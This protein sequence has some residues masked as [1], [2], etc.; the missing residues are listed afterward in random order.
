LK[1]RLFAFLFVSITLIVIFAFTLSYYVVKSESELLID[2]QIE[3]LS[4]SLISSNLTLQKLNQFEVTDNQ[5]SEIL[6]ED[7]INHVI[8]IFD[9]DQA[10]LY[11]NFTAQY[12]DVEFQNKLGWSTELLSGHNLRIL[13]LKTPEYYLRIGVILDEAL[14]RWTKNTYRMI[15]YGL[16]IISIGLSLSYF[17]TKRTM[18]PLRDMTSYLMFL[19]NQVENNPTLLLA[20]PLESGP[21]LKQISAN[22][23]SDSTD[24][25]N[26][27]VDTFERFLGSL[28]D[29]SENSA[30]RVSL[31]THELKTPLTVIQNNIE[32]II[33]SLSHSQEDLNHIKKIQDEISHLTKFINDFLEWSLIVNQMY[34]N[35]EVYAIKLHER[36]LEI[37]QRY[38]DETRKRIEYENKSRGPI[39]L[40]A[41]PWHLELL[42]NNVIGNAIKYSPTNQKVKVTLENYSLSIC[43]QGSGI[44]RTVLDKLGKPFNFEF[45]VKAN[46][47]GSGLG[48]AFIDII[49]KK[50]N[51]NLKIKS[52][53]K[54]T[55]VE[56][57]FPDEKDEVI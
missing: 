43:D 2:E 20:G 19:R 36:I 22:K 37:I 25:W 15:L 51:W 6:G 21:M 7:K 47:K 55:E 35:N 49:T 13:T 1:N 23:G 9:N 39:T 57:C 17:I 4:A 45:N 30:L 40:F 27:L 18:R 54:G 32:K 8:S 41:H 48:L 10:E 38:S 14:S 44:P 34:T 28:K 3:N 50:Y 12:L 24:E 52:Q 29:Y 31:L 53:D 46:H 42:L 16:L 56:I 11:S 33:P 26:N 5:I